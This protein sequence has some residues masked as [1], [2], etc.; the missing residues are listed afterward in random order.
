MGV[1]KANIPARFDAPEVEHIDNVCFSRWPNLTRSQALRLIV[2]EHRLLT[3]AGILAYPD[4]A[5]QREHC[6]QIVPSKVIDSAKGQG[7]EGSKNFAHGGKS[8]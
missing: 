6:L 3:L 4:K 5:S 1:E 7:T 2:M 8:A